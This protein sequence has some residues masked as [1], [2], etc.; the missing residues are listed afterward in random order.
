MESPNYIKA[1]LKPNGSK[2][3][4]RKVWSIDLESVWL[5]FFTATNLMG[6]T[7]ISHDAMGAP[8]RLA[9]EADGSVKFSKTGRPVIKVVKDIADSVRLVRENLM[10]GLMAFTHEVATNDPEGYK[11]EIEANA[12]AGQPIVAKDGQA[13][14]DAIFALAQA[15]QEAL[16]AERPK[17]RRKAD[18]EAPV[19]PEGEK[20]AELIPA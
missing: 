15:Q 16:K 12:E 8:L 3:K 13:L 19:A 6:D 9:Y 18:V 7:A 11:A 17:S 14:S 1:L 2:P 20:E 4:G 5:P 10:A